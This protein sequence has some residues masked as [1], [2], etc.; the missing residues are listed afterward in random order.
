[1]HLYFLAVLFELRAANLGGLQDDASWSKVAACEH[2]LGLHFTKV[3]PDIDGRR[4]CRTSILVGEPS[5]KKE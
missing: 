1:M 2:L 5:P 3:E 4:P